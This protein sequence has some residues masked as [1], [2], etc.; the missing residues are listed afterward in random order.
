MNLIRRTRLVLSVFG[1][2]LALSSS[3]FASDAQDFVK[4]KQVELSELVSK[5][6]SAD[7]EKK[8]VS[9]FDAVLDYDALAKDTLKDS[10]QEHSQAERDEFA[11]LLKELVR[12]AYRR[13][14][15]KTMGYDVDYTGEADGDSGKT[16]K[17]IARNR[18]KTHEEPLDID[19]VVHQVDGQWRIRDIVT[20]GS[21]LVSNYRSQF[22]RII[23][24]H[25]FPELLKKMK[26]KRDKADLD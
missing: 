23:K 17:T 18:K 25:G 15:K 2:A 7:D 26:A 13:N 16:V 21:S 20:A 6:K 8:V 1:L 11:G 5:S 4:G 22:R 9:A 19:Y 14:L 24:K 3:A 10:W 12:N